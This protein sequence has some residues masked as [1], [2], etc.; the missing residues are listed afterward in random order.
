MLRRGQILTKARHLGGRSVYNGSNFV[1]IQHRQQAVR[2]GWSEMGKFLLSPAPWKMRR[3]CFL[4]KIQAAALTGMESYAV[5]WTEKLR[6]DKMLAKY[7]RAMM[8]GKAFKQEHGKIF[9]MSNEEVFKH[10]RVLPSN[11]ELMVRRLGWLQQMVANTPAHKQTVA[12][13]WGH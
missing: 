6:L 7:L 1:E 8:K 11:G 4:G 10:W 13:L 12:A 9:N 5:T 2:A 3:V